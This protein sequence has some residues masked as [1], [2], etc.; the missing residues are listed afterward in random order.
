MT[1]RPSIVTDENLEYLD[2]LRESGVTNMWGAGAYL[3]EAFEI[4]E[5]DASI[6]LGYW[7]ETF[8]ERHPSI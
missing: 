2:T 3:R 4:E 7:M 5:S 1:K 8:S 6:I